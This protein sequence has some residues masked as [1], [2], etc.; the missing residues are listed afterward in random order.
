MPN[1]SNS[2]APYLLPLD[3]AADSSLVGAKAAR[4]ADAIAADLPVPS[5]L[6]LTDKAFQLFL[7][8]NALQEEIDKACRGL[9]PA[10]PIPIAQAAKRISRL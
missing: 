4:L 6:V 9:D 3:R 5:A 2:I 8:H 7:R 10:Q 1:T